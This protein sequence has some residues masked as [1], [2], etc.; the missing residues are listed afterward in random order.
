MI[1]KKSTLHILIVVAGLYSC[2]K[3]ETTNNSK[4]GSSIA[5]ENSLFI[6]TQTYQQG[7]LILGNKLN[8]P[9]LIQNITTA[10][11]ALTAKGTT[12]LKPINIRPTY[13]YVKFKPANIDQY[14][15]LAADSTLALSDFPLDYE[16]IQNGNRYHDPAIV[17]R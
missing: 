4:P 12:S 13:Y 16:I 10:Y 2:S 8:N 7:D 6:S 15:T 11:K 14:E 1:S 17:R 5:E 9:Y 3:P